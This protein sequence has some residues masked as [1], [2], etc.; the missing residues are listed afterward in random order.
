MIGKLQKKVKQ[1]V[2]F[3]VSYIFLRYDAGEGKLVI[4]SVTI[5]DEGTYRCTGTNRFGSGE[6]HCTGTNRFGSGE[7]RCTLYWDKQIRFRSVPLY[8]D[9]QIRFR[10]V[11]L[12]WDKLT[13]KTS[14]TPVVQCSCVS[15][16]C[17]W[18]DS[19]R[20]GLKGF[21]G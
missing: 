7:Y 11:P 8:W 16:F 10:S 6:Y 9:K 13:Q 14:L 15:D 4:P 3:T 17:P 18:G 2:T 20:K 19:G 5:E 12:Y 21:R 1:I